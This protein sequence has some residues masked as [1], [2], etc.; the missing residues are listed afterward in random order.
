MAFCACGR[1]ARSPPEMRNGS[2]VLN[3]PRLVAPYLDQLAAR[4]APHQ[5]ADAE[6]PG[7]AFVA[8]AHAVDQFAELGRGDGDDVVALVG[9]PLP[10]RVTILGRREHGAE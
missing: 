2:F 8:V 6:G 7:L 5:R 10:R 3:A 1:K 4:Q 9:K